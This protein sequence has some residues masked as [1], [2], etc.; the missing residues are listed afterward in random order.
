M[1]RMKKIIDYLLKK[2]MDPVR[3]HIFAYF[4]IILGMI[5]F[6]ECFRF[7]RHNWVYQYFVEPVFY[8]SYPGLDFIRPL[9]W[10]GM[11]YLFITMGILSFVLILGIFS[12][13]VCALLFCLF[14]YQFLIDQ[15]QYLNH[16]YL[17]QLILLC[18]VFLPLDNCWSI[19]P[20]GRSMAS[21]LDL[22]F[23]RFLVAV[24][25]VGGGIAKLN[26]D[27][28]A[29]EPMR[30]WLWNR[31]DTPLIG[32]FY[33]NPDVAYFY[34]Y[35]GLLFD[36]FI[37][38]AL[39]YPKTRKLA[40]VAVL[41]FHINNHFI[42]H[43]GIFPWFMILATP[44]FFNAHR[45]G[46]ETTAEFKAP[47][48]AG[49]SK[50]WFLI[51]FVVIQLLLPFRHLL[52]KGSVHWTEKGHRFSWHMKLRSKNGQIHFL[53]RDGESGKEEQ[54]DPKVYLTRRQNRKMST[55]PG[56]IRQ[57]AHFLETVYEAKGW[58]SVE[59]RTWAPCSLNGRKYQLLV[60]PMIDLTQDELPE[61]WILPLNTPLDQRLYPH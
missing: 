31:K 3:P 4:R 14:S 53:V 55:R 15:S 10:N 56:M 52:Y 20:S 37:V 30:M 32:K 49:M 45:F 9:S 59:V 2:S 17:I 51:I 25:Y 26:W 57:F 50:I 35:G 22:Y 19:K 5:L 23:L 16:F 18:C 1:V 34:S 11:N 54:V 60:D 6:V 61:G 33:E 41:I 12:R 46:P 36:L 47:P 40:V 48:A 13:V 58:K 39:L 43:I 8:F 42:F 29:G 24:P 28:L 38:P 21:I 7:F 44:V 27:W